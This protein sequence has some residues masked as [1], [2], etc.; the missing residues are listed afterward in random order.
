MRALRKKCG[1][2]R[3]VSRVMGVASSRMPMPCGCAGDQ[4]TADHGVAIVDAA[5]GATMPDRRSPQRHT[6]HRCRYPGAVM[7]A[8]SRPNSG[9]AISRA[10]G[11]PGFAKRRQQIG[12]A[13]EQLP[14]QREQALARE[15]QAPGRLDPARLRLGEVVA[16]CVAQ[17]ELPRVQLEAA[18]IS[19]RSRSTKRLPVPADVVDEQERRVEPG[20]HRGVTQII[21]VAAILVGVADAG[22]MT[23]DAAGATTA[24]RR[25]APRGVELNWSAS[26]YAQVS[27]SHCT[28]ELSYSEVG[29]SALYSSSFGGEAA[30]PAQVHAAVQAGFHAVASFPPAAARPPR[31]M[32]SMS[33]RSWRTASSAARRARRSSSRGRRRPAVSTSSAVNS[34]QAVSSQ[35]GLAGDLGEREAQ[36]AGMLAPI[37]SGR[38]VGGAASLSFPPPRHARS[39]RSRHAPPRWLPRR[40]WRNRCCRCDSSRLTRRVRHCRR[41][42][43]RSSRR[44]AGAA[45]GHQHRRVTAPSWPPTAPH[46]HP[47]ARA[48]S[49]SAAACRRINPNARCGKATYD[50][51]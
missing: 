15:Q 46:R 18:R 2:K 21:D 6:A 11:A 33:R 10:A 40:L 25:S 42:R 32:P 26:G 14:Q 1:T 9:L 51:R 44:P 50:R 12:M 48:G 28:T 36:G 31:G 20:L 38:R 8:P 22:E 45:P 5:A 27:H 35:Y 37:R 34:Q 16:E 3:L 19:R 39:H 41:W 43:R 30:V 24:R 13:R 47:S 49:P 4:P 17:Q 29:V 23:C 7:L